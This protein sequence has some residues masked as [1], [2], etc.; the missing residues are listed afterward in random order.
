VLESIA[1]EIGLDFSRWLEDVGSAEVRSHVQRD[2]DEARSLEIRRTP[3]IFVN[4]RRYSDEF[5]LPS[6]KDWV[7][8]ELG[9]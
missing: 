4:G 6:M 9:R 7:D 8:E 1:K 3:G 5:D 2:R